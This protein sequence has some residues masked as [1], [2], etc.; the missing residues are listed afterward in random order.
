MLHG[1]FFAQ[2]EVEVPTEELTSQPPDNRN[3]LHDNLEQ[4]Y[5]FKLNRITTALSYSAAATAGIFITL[6]LVSFLNIPNVS[7]LPPQDRLY[8]PFYEWVSS[9]QVVTVGTWDQEIGT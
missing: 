3:W 8:A 9:E 7:P 5:K 4:K 2:L 1:E 6:L